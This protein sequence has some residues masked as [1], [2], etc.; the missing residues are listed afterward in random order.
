MAEVEIHP[1][2]PWRNIVSIAAS[3]GPSPPAGRAILTLDAAHQLTSDDG[4]TLTGAS[5]LSYL[6]GPGGEEDLELAI[7]VID[8]TTIAL[9]LVNFVGPY[10]GGATMANATT[11]EHRTS[12]SNRQAIL[13]GSALY[14]VMYYQ[15][16]SQRQSSLGE[17]TQIR[18]YKSVNSGASWSEVDAANHPTFIP[19]GEP[20]PHFDGTAI[21]CGFYRENVTV[22]GAT[23]RKL[24]VQKF[25]LS[26]DLW[27][28]RSTATNAPLGQPTRPQPNPYVMPDGRVFLFYEHAE[29]PS[30]GPLFDSARPA[31]AIYDPVGDT[32][33]TA[34]N[35]FSKPNN[36]VIGVTAGSPGVIT[37]GTPHGYLTGDAV[38]VRNVGGVS[39]ANGDF[40]ITVVSPNSFSL[41]GSNVTGAYTGGGDTH[42]SAIAGSQISVQGIARGTGNL[43][44]LF[45][46]SAITGEGAPQRAYLY[47]RTFDMG[48]AALSGDEQVVTANGASR[49]N[50]G[51][52]PISFSSGGT[53]KLAWPIAWRPAVSPVSK[54]V[55]A[56]ADSALNPVWAISDVDTSTPPVVNSNYGWGMALYDPATNELHIFWT[57]VD[58]VPTGRTNIVARTKTVGGSWGTASTFKTGA[59]YYYADPAPGI[60]NGTIRVVYTKVHPNELGP[61]AD[62]TNELDNFPHI[63]VFIVCPDVGEGNYSYFD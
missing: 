43:L 6:G 31:W 33:D 27:G 17:Q 15:P 7:T 47:Q 38:S 60:F 50:G 10:N 44:H 62:V 3:A 22:G 34:D 57:I 61:L 18:M 41:D 37:T 46:G 24:Y 39:G 58:D 9:D 51:N 12:N 20:I 2:P 30:D 45:Y 14:Y 52:L 8:S 11:W 21:W 29:T 1:K 25:D 59:E 49:F 32:W 55:I 26:T 19:M 40:S 35:Y 23:W 13:F 42:V 63:D 53:T 56:E 54:L 28:A 16:G 5:G 4:I 48:L 36:T